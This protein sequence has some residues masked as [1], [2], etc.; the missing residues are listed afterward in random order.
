MI[1]AGTPIVVTIVNLFYTVELTFISFSL[2]IIEGFTGSRY[3]DFYRPTLPRPSSR[4]T[5]VFRST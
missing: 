2:T 3:V 5:P 4:L 1:R